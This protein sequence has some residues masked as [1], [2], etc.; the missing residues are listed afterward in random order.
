MEEL[1]FDKNKSILPFLKRMFGY[2][3]KFE[4]KYFILMLTFAGIVGTIDSSFPKLFSMFIHDCLGNQIEVSKENLWAL[5][6]SPC[7]QNYLWILISIILVLIS[8]VMIF[9]Y[10]A[11]AIAERI[12]FHMRRQLFE[13]YQALPFSYF[14]QN[15]SGWLLSR[16]S[17]DTDR[18]SEV[19]SWGLIGMAWATVSIF[20]CF[21]I[22]VVLYCLINKMTTIAFWSYAIE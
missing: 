21:G 19:I 20:F 18:I 15:S 11:G 13:K 4:K 16:I 5:V 1:E 3:W 7:F 2:V 17:S 9:V 12:I 6:S 10:S 22:N 8:S 14:D